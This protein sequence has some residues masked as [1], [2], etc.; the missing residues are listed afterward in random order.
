MEATQVAQQNLMERL[1]Q[2]QVQLAHAKAQPKAQARKRQVEDSQQQEANPAGGKAKKVKNQRKPGPEVEL[3]PQEA[4][5]Q[6]KRANQMGFTQVFSRRSQGATEEALGNG[7]PE[8]AANRDTGPAFHVSLE[9]RREVVLHN[10][11][12]DLAAL[13]AEEV[14]TEADHNRKEMI[15]DS[16]DQESR[17]EDLAVRKQ[18][19]HADKHRKVKDHRPGADMPSSSTGEG[20]A[21]Q[22]SSRARSSCSGAR[23]TQG[24]EAAGGPG[25]TEPPSARGGEDRE[26]R[27][28]P[29]G[30]LVPAV[31][32]Q[33]GLPEP[34]AAPQVTGHGQCLADQFSSGSVS[35]V[36]RVGGIPLTHHAALR[37]VG[38]ELVPD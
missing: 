23:K 9:G 38:S 10:R 27:A 33:A 29:P 20:S 11:F 4:A 26:E 6:R 24:P 35:Q 37:A 1:R 17:L 25:A 19:W 12:A 22:G 2:G 8:E 34:L 21:Q 18:R 5:E 14:V 15:R 32:R 16:W 13:R 36:L 7:T 31:G 30:R 28:A 3:T